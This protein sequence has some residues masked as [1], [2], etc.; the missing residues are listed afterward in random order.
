MKVGAWYIKSVVGNGTDACQKLLC[1]Y[2][3]NTHTEKGLSTNLKYEHEVN[4]L[5]VENFLPFLYQISQSCMRCSQAGKDEC[6]VGS[7]H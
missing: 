7:H 6:Y 5:S 2:W 4:L 3:Y 1:K